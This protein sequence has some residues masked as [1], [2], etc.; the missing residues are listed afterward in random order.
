MIGLVRQEASRFTSI[1]IDATDESEALNALQKRFGVLGL[2]TIV[3]IDGA[4][5]V[6][7]EPRV[8]GFVDAKG[9]LDLMKRVR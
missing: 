7:T 1:K 5:N 9:Y 2:P 6:L 4:G 8:T 3:F